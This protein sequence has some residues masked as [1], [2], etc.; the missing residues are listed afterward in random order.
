MRKPVDPSH[1]ENKP[2]PI[3]SRVAR[4]ALADLDEE[5]THEVPLEAVIGAWNKALKDHERQGHRIVKGPVFSSSSFYGS[6]LAL[7]YEYEWDN[8]AYAAEKE[9]WDAKLAKYQEDLA[10]W[11][12]FEEDRRNILNPQRNIKTIDDQIRRAE[13]RLANLKAVKANEPL[14]FPES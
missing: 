11:K 6:C 8:L 10:A 4:L 14:P 7:T 2:Q 13:H 9:A 3:H 12:K 5:R 1:N